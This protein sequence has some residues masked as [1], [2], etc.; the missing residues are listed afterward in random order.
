MGGPNSTRWRGY[1]RR[2]LAEQ[3][4]AID[5]GDRSWRSALAQTRAEGT[6]EWRNPQRATLRGWASYLLAPTSECGTRRNLVLDTSGDEFADKQVVELEL[7][8]AGWSDP[9]WL[10]RC[11]DHCGRR[12]QKIYAANQG[13]EFS[14]WR[15]SGLTHRSSQQHDARLDQALRDPVGFLE[16]RDRAPRTPHS[17][18]VT[19]WLVIRAVEREVRPKTG[20]RWGRRSF[21]AWDRVIAEMRAEYELRQ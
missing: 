16:A 11:P 14:C 20:R 8:P 12:A 4:M 2:P 18:R 6:V 7:A 5:L 19:S 21:T 17:R 9:R 13:D 10:A 1:A 3:A 15:C